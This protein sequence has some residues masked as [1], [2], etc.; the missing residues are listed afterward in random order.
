MK[1]YISAAWNETDLSKT[2]SGTSYQL[3]KE[4]ETFCDVERVALPR[5]AITRILA[6]LNKKTGCFWFQKLMS[7]YKNFKVNRQL[8]DKRIPVLSIGSIRALDAPTYIYVDNLFASCLLFKKYKDEGW[9]YSPY[10]DVSDKWIKESIKYEHSVLVKAKAI[11]CMGEWLAEHAKKVYPDCAHKIF[12]ARGGVNSIAEQ[13]DCSREKNSVLFVGRDFKRKAGDLVIKA[14]RSLNEKH[15]INVKLY[16]AGPKNRPENSDYPW[17][18]FL[19]DI[20]YAETGRMMQKASLFC[21]PSRFEAYGIVFA[22]AFV[23]GIPCIGRDAFEMRNFIQQG[24]TGELIREDDVDC[25]ADKIRKVLETDT[26]LTNV[27]R[28]KQEYL[29]K[30]NWHNIALKVFE[31]IRH[32]E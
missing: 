23:A 20:S 27:R 25:L 30:Y 12:V 19:G 6:V 18:N 2:W 8:K 3:Y 31:Q 9:G 1:I 22:E 7:E 29:S 14:V 24:L 13:V 16:L 11:F 15:G 21:M 28:K 5:D 10:G 32:N 17:L 26:Y 4:L